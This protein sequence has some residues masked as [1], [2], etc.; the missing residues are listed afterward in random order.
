MLESLHRTVADRNVDVVVASQPDAAGESAADV[1]AR[2]PWVHHVVLHE[3]KGFAGANNLAVSEVDCTLVAFLNPDLILTEGWLDPLEEALGDPT[4]T[5]AAPPLLTPGGEIDEAGQIMYSDGGSEPWG[6][7]GFAAPYDRIMFSRDVDYASAACWLVRRDDFLG[8]GGFCTEYH[9]AYFEDVDFAFR[10]RR[11]GGRTRLVTKRPVV[12][13]HALPKPDRVGIAMSSRE[14]FRHR[15]A[16][17]LRS[18]PDRR[19]EDEGVERVRDH[20]CS[21]RR[22]EVVPR[23]IGVA[24][25]E[26]RVAEAGRWAFEHPTARMTVHCDVYPMVEAWR[27]QWCPSGLELLVEP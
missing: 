18:Q 10:A 16:D 15:Q 26:R 4:V 13:D 17:E 25:A 27:R 23:G 22:L 20:F 11:S 1:V 5:I 7:S 3:N 12:H 24:E 21:D 9:P 2:F 19:S 8:L 6:G 14:I